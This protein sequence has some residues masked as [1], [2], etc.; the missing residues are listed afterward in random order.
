MEGDLGVLLGERGSISL[1]PWASVD[2]VAETCCV[3]LRGRGLEKTLR[4]CKHQRREVALVVSGVEDVIRMKIGGAM[5]K[6]HTHH[7]RGRR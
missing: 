7:E 3:V 4:K 6:A 5:A 1:R 2:P